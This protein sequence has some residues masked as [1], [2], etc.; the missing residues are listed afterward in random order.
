MSYTPFC[1]PAALV[2]AVLTALLVPYLSLVV[3]AIAVLATAASVVVIAATAVAAPLAARR[4]PGRHA[5][6]VS[7]RSISCSS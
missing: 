2:V 4:R 6:D 3:A 7:E 5:T 1:T